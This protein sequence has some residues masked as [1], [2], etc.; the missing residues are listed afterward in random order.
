MTAKLIL[1]KAGR[2]VLPRKLRETL[3]LTAGDALQLESEGDEITL[4]PVR[5]VA[6]LRKEKGIW[7]YHGERSSASI[8]DLI[9]RVREERFFKKG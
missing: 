4:R 1:D 7:V 8:P 2:L 3:H 9:D 6:P 5:P